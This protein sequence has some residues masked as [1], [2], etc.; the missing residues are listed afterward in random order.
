VSTLS[1]GVGVDNST[2]LKDIAGELN[3]TLDGKA[4]NMT[5]GTWQAAFLVVGVLTDI[6]RRYPNTP[7]HEKE[8]EVRFR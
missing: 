6:R 1:Q 3:D 4:S 2:T 7:V 8:T 5:E